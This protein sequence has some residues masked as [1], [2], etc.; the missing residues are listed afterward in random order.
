MRITLKN[1]FHDREVQINAKA[2][3]GQDGSYTIILTPRQ[4]QRTKRILCG[5]ETCACSNNAGT[6]GAQEAPAGKKIALIL[7]KE[8]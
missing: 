8:V 5:I 3:D 2:I 1:D 7:V 4:A 6:R